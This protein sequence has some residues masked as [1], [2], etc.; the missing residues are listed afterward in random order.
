MGAWDVGIYDNDDAADWSAELA[1]RGL[2][3]VEDALDAALD[4]GYI[5]APEGACAL[6]AADV[7]ARLVSGRGDDSA[8]CESVVTWVAAHPEAPPPA[9]VAKAARAV[10]RIGGEDSELAELWSETGADSAQWRLTLEGVQQRLR[11]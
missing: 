1:D 3:A 11:A 6:A 8:Y 5:E 10:D 2:M 4:A 9:L 7:I